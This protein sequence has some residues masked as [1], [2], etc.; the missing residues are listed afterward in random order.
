VP[1]GQRIVKVRKDVY[2]G[3]DEV[4]NRLGLTMIVLMDIAFSLGVAF[5][6]VG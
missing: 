1:A 6:K 5:K 4:N 2:E 3:L